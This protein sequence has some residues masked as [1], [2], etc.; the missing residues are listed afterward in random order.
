MAWL[1][2]A[3]PG[4]GARGH[5][6]HSAMLGCLR[7]CIYGPV[8]S[9]LPQPATANSQKSSSHTHTHIGCRDCP[10]KV[11]P[12]TFHKY[13]PGDMPAGAVG[14]QYFP[15]DTST[16]WLHRLHD[17]NFFVLQQDQCR[18]WIYILL[19]VILTPNLF[20]TFKQ[21]VKLTQRDGWKQD[22][23]A[24]VFFRATGG[25]NTLGLDLHLMIP[26]SVWLKQLSESCW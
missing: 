16:L 10:S 18:P 23:T 8:G 20:Y 9:D 1:H 2:S 15:E 5:E 6:H 3:W 19:H 24:A 25:S 4:L 17:Y 12:L 26:H 22:V 13:T 21:R 7:L 14:I 11:P